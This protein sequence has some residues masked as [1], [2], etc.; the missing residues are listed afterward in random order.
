MTLFEE[1]EELGGIARRAARAMPNAPGMLDAISLVRR[2]VRGAGVDV[3][4]GTRASAETVLATVPDVVVAA[5]GSVPRQGA[6]QTARPGATVA[7]A[8]L[9]H[10]VSS[11]DVLAL[12]TVPRRRSWSTRSVAEGAIGV[13]ELLVEGAGAPGRQPV[14]SVGLP[15]D[16][17]GRASTALGRLR[18]TAGSRRCRC[19]WSSRSPRPPSTSRTSS[20]TPC[21]RTMRA[22]W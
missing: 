22:W 12:T 9:P 15:V 20:G 18:A 5:T 21:P 1:T 8:D 13:A 14:A 6:R 4:L 16:A 11:R 10:V 17:T 3:R 19:R 7:G 2:E